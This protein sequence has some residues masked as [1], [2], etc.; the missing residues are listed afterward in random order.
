[1]SSTLKKIKITS[2]GHIV[3]GWAVST[4]QRS[5]FGSFIFFTSKLAYWKYCFDV[6]RAE[7]SVFLMRLRRTL[8]G[9]GKIKSRF[10]DPMTIITMAVHWTMKSSSH[11]L[12]RDDGLPIIS[13]FN[14]NVFR[15]SNDPTTIITI[16]FHRTKGIRFG[17]DIVS[18]KSQF[19]FATKCANRKSER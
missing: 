14:L 2:I 11:V 10:D 8:F 19:D 9:V 13:N 4:E 1:M 15:A 18:G 6:H 12:K 5:Q 3:C 7:N 16:N 17:S